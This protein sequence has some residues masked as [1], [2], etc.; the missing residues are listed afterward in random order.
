MKYHKTPLFRPNLHF[1]LCFFVPLHHPDPLPYYGCGR[2]SIPT[3]LVLC[4]QGPPATS[5]RKPLLREFFSSN[6]FNS[7]EPPLITPLSPWSNEQFSFYLIV[8]LWWH[9]NTLREQRRA[10]IWLFLS[11]KFSEGKDS[12]YSSG[13]LALSSTLSLWVGASDEYQFAVWCINLSGEVSLANME[14]SLIFCA[15]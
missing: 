6:I 1:Q 11:S 2:Q 9:L 7:V 4:P 15:S 5:Y 8:A 10:N 13:S 12:I 14:G 3:L